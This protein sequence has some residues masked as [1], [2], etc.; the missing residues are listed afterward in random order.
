[1]FEEI[2]KAVRKIFVGPVIS[3]ANTSI[4]Y[5]L[6]SYISDMNDGNIK[7][8]GKCYGERVNNCYLI[9]HDDKESKDGNGIIMG[10][11]FL[12]GENIRYVSLPLYNGIRDAKMDVALI[13][14]ALV[15]VYMVAACVDN[16]FDKRCDIFR[17]N[18]LNSHSINLLNI[19]PALIFI[20]VATDIFK[21]LCTVDDLKKAYT[22]SKFSDTSHGYL[23]G[24]YYDAFYEANIIS[25]F[26]FFINTLI[27]YAGNY[28]T[29]IDNHF[30]EAYLDNSRILPPYAN[31]CIEKKCKAK[32]KQFGNNYDE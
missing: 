10:T 11:C 18:D 3:T 6:S 26:E 24:H 1:M 32:E 29:T 30:I 4:P 14:M 27:D 7:Y 19:S 22:E 15:S 8:N 17:Y 5:D 23:Y 9:T 13:N 16:F 31:Y 28:T 12:H 20:K 21:D 2:Y 25:S